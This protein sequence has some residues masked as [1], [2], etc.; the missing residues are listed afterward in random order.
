MLFNSW[1][2][3]IFFLL[4]FPLYYW[5]VPSLPNA[6]AA[7]VGL[8]IAASLVFY[9]YYLPWLL[10]LFVISMLVNGFAAQVLFL[11]NVPKAR[12]RLILMVAV[13]FNVG[14]L[15]YFK[16]ASLIAQTILPRSVYDSLAHS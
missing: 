14:G 5:G 7:Q 8:L 16:Y 6:R 13:C 12:R 10:V 11:D 4:V 3:A 1:A 9:G 15:A 2:F